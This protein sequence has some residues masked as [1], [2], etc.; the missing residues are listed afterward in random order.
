MIVCSHC[1]HHNL[2][3]GANCEACGSSL[4]DKKNCPNCGSTAQDDARFCGVCGFNLQLSMPQRVEPIHDKGTSN[5]LLLPEP[6]PPEPTL[7]ISSVDTSAAQT[8]SGSA[9]LEQEQLR[10]A[11]NTDSEASG[12]DSLDDPFIDDEVLNTQIQVKTK[13]KALLHVQ[14][15]SL[16]EL[17]GYQKVVHI[18]KP[19][20]RVPPDINVSV[21]PSSE[22]VSRVHADI[23]L[24]GGNCFVEDVGSANGTYLNNTQLPPGTR[25]P[26][27]NGDRI[28][29][30]K[31]DL[32]TF[33]CQMN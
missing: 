5:D 25:H 2:N 8:A 28:C 29:L 20:D 33:I 13:S 3:E 16:I 7:S 11:K 15:N 1:L 18:G 27:R 9:S 19:N 30:G 31:G 22:V 21:F 32:V 12:K 17:S 4:T 26:L 23:H 14:S 24:E 6:P 10:E